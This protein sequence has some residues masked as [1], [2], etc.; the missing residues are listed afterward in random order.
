MSGFVVG[1]VVIELVVTNIF[2][3]SLKKHLSAVLRKLLII[4]HTD[5]FPDRN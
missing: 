4:S 2:P 3:S 1:V 5:A